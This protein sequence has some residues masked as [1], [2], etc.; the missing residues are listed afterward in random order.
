MPVLT[1]AQALAALGLTVQVNEAIGARGQ[2]QAEARAIR[3]D[4]LVAVT[5]RDSADEAVEALYKSVTMPA[6]RTR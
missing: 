2:E 4:V 5:L 6:R 1:T 3:N